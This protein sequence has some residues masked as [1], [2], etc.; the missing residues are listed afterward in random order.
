MAE[1]IEP[2]L[3]Q[4]VDLD[5]QLKLAKSQVTAATKSIEAQKKA[6]A[7]GAPPLQKFSTAAAPSITAR[8]S[9]Q[10]SSFTGE[11]TDHTGTGD[12]TLPLLPPSIRKLAS[13]EMAVKL[14]QQLASGVAPQGPDERDKIIAIAKSFAD[15]PKF[16]KKV[17]EKLEA[18]TFS[19][20]QK[21]RVRTAGNLLEAA[22]KAF[23]E[24]D[25]I[26]GT[27][28]QKGEESSFREFF[29]LGGG[30]IDSQS[31]G[32]LTQFLD[33]AMLQEKNIGA[34]KEVRVDLNRNL[35]TGRLVID[36]PN[37]AA[38]ALASHTRKLVREKGATYLRELDPETRDEIL[39]EARDRASSDVIAVAMSARNLSMFDPGDVD[40]KELAKD[41]FRA[42][43]AHITKRS[44]K[45]GIYEAFSPT[46]D[47]LA[48]EGPLEYFLRAQ[49]PLDWMA[50]KM[51]LIR[52]KLDAEGAADKYGG[53]ANLYAV[54]AY[55]PI[56]NDWAMDQLGV[57]G[58]EEVRAY[59]DGW[60]W[61]EEGKVKHAS[62]SAL[63][64]EATGGDAEAVRKNSQNSAMSLTLPM[65]AYLFE[66]DV[67]FFATMG[68]GK[69]LSAAKGIKAAKP[70][71]TA[72]TLLRK[73]AKSGDV[74]L[75]TA[76][77]ELEKVDKVMG[78]H[79]KITITAKNGKSVASIDDAVGQLA[80]REE[81]AAAAEEV[82]RGSL[83]TKDIDDIADIARLSRDNPEIATQLADVVEKRA[84]VLGKA[85]S[86][87]TGLNQQILETNKSIDAQR[88]AKTTFETA[89]KT[90]NKKAAELTSAMNK[91]EGLR[92]FINAENVLLRTTGELKAAMAM[93]DQAKV[94]AL[95]EKVS[96]AQKATKEARK[97]LS[98]D[99]KALAK[100]F[101]KET[102]TLSATVRE[103]AAA[104]HGDDV[105]K[106]LIKSEKKFRTTRLRFDPIV[107]T[108]ENTLTQAT[109]RMIAA[110]PKAARAFTKK[111]ASEGIT[112]S[113]GKTIR[114]SQKLVKDF[115]KKER[116]LSDSLRANRWRQTA[117]GLAD[118]YE[119]AAKVV[120]KVG[121][122]RG[123]IF[124]KTGVLGAKTDDALEIFSSA[125]KRDE[126]PEFSADI[127]A[128]GVT[129]TAEKGGRSVR[130]ADSLGEVVSDAE[131][132]ARVSDET[133]DLLRV[134]KVVDTAED[135]LSSQATI[136]NIQSLLHYAQ[137]NGLGLDLAA[138]ELGPVRDY[139]RA[140]G[141]Q[142]DSSGKFGAEALR[143]MELGAMSA[144]LGELGPG[145]LL[146]GAGVFEKMVSGFGEAAAKFTLKSG[147]EAGKLLSRA[148]DAGVP[149]RITLAQAEK[150]QFEL[151]SIL[152]K[153][154]H[155]LDPAKK[156]EKL[157]AILMDARAN[158]PTFKK[159]WL[160]SL[161]SYV[162]DVLRAHD[163]WFQRLG[164]AS[165]DVAK[166]V[167]GGENLTEVAWEEYQL[168]LKEAGKGRDA[169]RQATYRYLDTSSRM[170]LPGS[171]ASVFNMGAKTI[172]QR[173]KRALLSDTAR[174][175]Y[176]A[177]QTEEGMAIANNPALLGLSRLWL[178]PGVAVPEKIANALYG[179]ALKNL[180][181]SSTAQEFIQLQRVS[182]T[183]RLGEGF[184][185]SV[186][187]AEALINK[188]VD[189][190]VGRVHAFATRSFI[191]GAAYDEVATIA[192]R[193]SMGIMGAEE[194]ADV[195]RLLT[196]DF[197]NIADL[198]MAFDRLYAMGIS[199]MDR[200]TD[201]GKAGISAWEE[202]NK[203]FKEIVKF[204]DDASGEA[205]YGLNIA[206]R[207][208][209]QSLGKYVKSLEAVEAGIKDPNKKILSGFVRKAMELWRTAAVT[210]LIVPNF[211][212]PI[213][214]FYGDWT[215]M[216]FSNGIGFANRALFQNVWAGVPKYG[217]MFQDRMSRLS[218]T[219]KQPQLRT[220]METLFNPHIEDFWQGK[221]GALRMGKNGPLVSYDYLRRR[222]IVDGIWDTQTSTDVLNLA[223]K[224]V[225]ADPAFM[226]LTKAG[227]KLDFIFDGAKNWQAG[228]NR[229]VQTMQQRQRVGTYLI[230]LKDGK[231]FDEAARLT[232]NAIYDWKHGISQGE[233]LY[234]AKAFPFIRWARLTSSQLTRGVL[235]GLT[236]PDLNKF[237]KAATGRTAMNRLKVMYRAQRD[238]VPYMMDSRSPEEIAE[239]EGYA[240]AV[241]RAL[242]P[243]WMKQSGAMMMGIS[244]VDRGDMRRN[245]EIYGD[246]G[247]YTHWA[248]VAPPNGLIDIASMWGGAASM[249]TGTLLRISGEKLA[250][251]DLQSKG[252]H[253]FSGMMYPAY[254]DWLEASAGIRQKRGG[255]FGQPQPI[256][257]TEAAILDSLGISTSF[258]KERNQYYTTSS[259]A[260][261]LTQ[262]PM[263]TFGAARI[264]NDWKFRNPAAG[265]DIAEQ[266]KYF[267]LAQTR[268]MRMYP[269]NV[270]KEHERL[271][272]KMSERAKIIEKRFEFDKN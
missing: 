235:E 159:G 250:G 45:G 14:R 6:M 1:T 78:A 249:I 5:T 106:E 57:T 160:N 156:H 28:F 133:P 109:R 91:S 189:P 164:T 126:V 54:A 103:A 228:I 247:K 134:E 112:G 25:A 8:T 242:Y 205:I 94:V 233:I 36:V 253:H 153:A 85:E 18:G 86:V 120:R 73:T 166:I 202:S 138:K 60:T 260:Q 105:L 212:R 95:S 272:K 43:K 127:A 232:R 80:K 132:I 167:R 263:V 170:L 216:I 70:L 62:L 21:F 119:A 102:K 142:L 92:N 69:G 168:V 35:K 11:E 51:K 152:A 150:I 83:A 208:L 63:V 115:V 258:N 186:K 148:I 227:G 143:G 219:T 101:R 68:I 194:A 195:N 192:K 77:N 176:K 61:A 240:N 231:S 177:L 221:Q 252:F 74:N 24:E 116:A 104:F 47:D 15:N 29:G 89:N 244:N 269:Y 107:A 181:K 220:F 84:R 174:H 7:K 267:A 214:D 125:V 234:S 172:F 201:I 23:P 178:P 191:T 4:E 190:R 48:S 239:E 230:H 209:D 122:Q 130:I 146:D 131:I 98:K 199:F 180:A 40:V 33:Q 44:S 55:I 215:Q 251:A 75:A 110:D 157:A 66:P 117:L 257:R 140:A 136:G 88:K 259:T 175:Q 165:E 16:A 12:T 264:A 79:A 145:V 169:V 65:A 151:S 236:R 17:L 64:A 39:K 42:F 161:G 162:K 114:D 113:V 137:R 243:Q 97:F 123:L 163:P 2:V 173:A 183:N 248:R 58:E 52:E 223:E 139:L 185:P 50:P 271:Q 72:A 141:M 226:N 270:Y 200:S 67:I 238:L 10:T 187:D 262:L 182:T 254:R 197:T 128:R 20:V 237:A 213:F 53:L 188:S 196:G 30:T 26:R 19:D 155:V 225:Q 41:P 76:I 38:K 118:D 158:H 207:S 129:E 13:P 49:S 198:D 93:G 59:V 46:V 111:M 147:G 27:T 81:E 266:M 229:W 71:V 3:P 265:E 9:R 124:T 90:L 245:A 256:N 184:V 224:L 82:L 121:G 37:T 135:P 241:A 179:D 261:L 246:E 203:T 255:G 210:G 171:K 96:K 211:G 206:R 34:D 218:K 193:A 87:R 144:R 108:A 100:S 22:R 56:A 268:A 204:S 222:S 31:P 99:Q 217:P 154:H 32:A 149:I